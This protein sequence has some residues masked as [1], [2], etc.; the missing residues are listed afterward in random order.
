[1]LYKYVKGSKDQDKWHLGGA[2]NNN[3]GRYHRPG[4]WPWYFGIKL[5]KNIR[6]LISI[7]ENS[8]W[9]F[10]DMAFISGFSRRSLIRWMTGKAY[11]NR[12]NQRKIRRYLYWHKI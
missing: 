12:K 2:Y 6:A 4:H 1:M 10:D 5:H 7:K 11:P 3:R 9:T 8:E